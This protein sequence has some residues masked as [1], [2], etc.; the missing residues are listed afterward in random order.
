MASNRMTQDVKEKFDLHKYFNSETP[1][2]LGN[3]QS[4]PSFYLPRF[5]LALTQ[6]KWNEAGKNAIIIF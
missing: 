2:S 1:L 5:G 3:K 6:I 4:F